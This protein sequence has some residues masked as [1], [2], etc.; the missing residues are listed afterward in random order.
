MIIFWKEAVSGGCVACNKKNMYFSNV[1]NKAAKAINEHDDNSDED[2][3]DKACY[4]N[5]TK[6][7]IQRRGPQYQEKH[8]SKKGN[9]LNVIPSTIWNDGITVNLAS[10]PY[11]QLVQYEG[12]G[13]R[14]VVP[15]LAVP[16]GSAYT[17]NCKVRGIITI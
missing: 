6:R 9:N 4:Q 5:Q 11:P 8:L 1:D 10:T 14:M 17:I 7:T 12:S 15:G 2:Y 3:E 16:F 13:F